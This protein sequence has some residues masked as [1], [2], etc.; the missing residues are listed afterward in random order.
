MSEGERDVPFGWGVGFNAFPH[1]GQGLGFLHV[2]WGL[3]F[4]VHV[5]QGLGFLHFE[6]GLGFRVHVGQGLGF[7]HFEWG[8]GFRV[9]FGQALGFSSTVKKISRGA[10][11]RRVKFTSCSDFPISLITLSSLRLS[12][13]RGPSTKKRINK[14]VPIQV[15]KLPSQRTNKTPS[16]ALSSSTTSPSTVSPSAS[17]H[18]PASAIA[19]VYQPHTNPVR[20]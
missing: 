16:L 4:R 13:L 9:H 8:L 3:G 17:S 12:L 10:S 2:E 18:L 19:I 5:G 11:H 15:S 6:W 7:L 14:L 20:F 1:F